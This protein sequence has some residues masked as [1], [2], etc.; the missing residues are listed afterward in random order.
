MPAAVA[1]PLITAGVSG[2]AAVGGAALSSRGMRKASDAQTS[3]AN[4]AAELEAK[5]ASDAL[6]FQR[7][8]EEQRRKEWQATQD[9][10]FGLWQAR[11][12][13][14]QPYRAFG[15]GALA[16]LAQPL[17]YKPGSLGD[18]MGGN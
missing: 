15:R 4:R 14:L 18:R 13:E 6:T 16:Q 17:A 8:Q 7:E 2:A 12:G 5:S 3:A 10:N 9:R 11:E 1:V